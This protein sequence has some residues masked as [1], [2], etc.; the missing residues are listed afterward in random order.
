[1]TSLVLGLPGTRHVEPDLQPGYAMFAIGIPAEFD[2][3]H[4]CDHLTDDKRGDEV[5]DQC[6]PIL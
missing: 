6:S 3:G 4:V 2:R 5:Y 1:M